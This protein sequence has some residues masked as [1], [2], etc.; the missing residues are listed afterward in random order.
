VGPLYIDT[1]L[2]GRL[3]AVS[4]AAPHASDRLAKGA[5]FTR[6]LLP[7]TLTASA[8]LSSYAFAIFFTGPFLLAFSWVVL[9]FFGISPKRAWRTIK[10]NYAA[11]LGRED[12]EIESISKLES[13]VLFIFGPLLLLLTMASSLAGFVFNLVLL[14]IA[15]VAH[16]L[17]KIFA[18]P[19]A[20]IVNRIGA[21]KKSFFSSDFNAARGVALL[22]VV[23]SIPFLGAG[24]VFI[25]THSLLLKDEQIILLCVAVISVSLSAAIFLVR[26]FPSIMI[27]SYLGLF[28]IPALGMAAYW[29]VW[30]V[31]PGRE[32]LILRLKG[33]NRA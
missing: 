31:G 17:V 24:Y 32:S 23:I 22:T 10:E 29:L 18:A 16:Y 5:S 2:F 8:T 30:A 7:Q 14:P 26:E 27:Y 33:L 6:V 15:F 11:G 13:I 9:F 19:S 3:R 25:H 28:I 4:A 1:D 21:D 12:H 20:N